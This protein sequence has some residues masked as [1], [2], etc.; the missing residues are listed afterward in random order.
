MSH[1]ELPRPAQGICAPAM[2][3]LTLFAE[4]LPACRAFYQEVFG[5]EPVYEDAVSAVFD[6]RSTLV[7]LLSTSASDELIAPASTAARAHGVR[8]VMTIDVPDVHEVC[9]ELSR[10]GVELLN[11]PIDRSW[12][13]RTASFVDPAGHVWEIAQPIGDGESK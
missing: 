10:R 3:V 4:D 12:G 9:E 6:F 11:G 2:H 8:F 7:N 13:R 5:L 1:G